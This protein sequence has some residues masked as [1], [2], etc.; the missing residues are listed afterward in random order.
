MTGMD[1]V[2]PMDSDLRRALGRVEPPAGFADRVL[3]RAKST[4]VAPKQPKAA[5]AGRWAIAATLV[6]AIGGGVYYR[7]GEQ[8][9]AEGEDAKRKVL[10]SLNIAGTKLHAVEVKVNHGEEH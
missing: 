6:A 9:R 3:Q 2:D 4:P 8:R 1:P 7:A 5:K 10:M